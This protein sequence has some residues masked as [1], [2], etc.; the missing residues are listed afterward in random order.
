MFLKCDETRLLSKNADDLMI[1]EVKIRP[2]LLR[3]GGGSNSQYSFQKRMGICRKIKVCEGAKLY[4]VVE[5]LAAKRSLKRK[6]KYKYH[7]LIKNK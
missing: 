3:R 1:V 2:I 5:K 4:V 6:I 7:C